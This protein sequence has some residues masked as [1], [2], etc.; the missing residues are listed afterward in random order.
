M[1]LHSPG[2]E[3]AVRRKAKAAVRAVP[4]LK[5]E[6]A[7]NRAHRMRS[8]SLPARAVAS[9]L[10]AFFVWT[11]AGTDG[12]FHATL[13]FISLWAG[14]FISIE[15]GSLAECLYQS[16]DLSALTLLPIEDANIFRWQLQK[17]FRKSL[18]LLLDLVLAFQALALRSSG[19]LLASVAAIVTAVFTWLVVAALACRLVVWRPGLPYQLAG[20]GLFAISFI[21]FAARDILWAPTLELAQRLGPALNM[22]LPTAWP[23][24]LLAVVC[25]KIHWSLLALLA[26]AGFL[27]TGTRS[28]L[29]QLR[30]VYHF[31]EPQA[32]PSLPEESPD[33]SDFSEIPDAGR[34]GGPIAGGIT[35]SEAVARNQLLASAQPSRAPGRLENLLWNWFSNRQRLLAE[36]AFPQGISIGRRWQVIFRDVAVTL[37]A[38]FVCG[39]FNPM[40]ERLVLSFGVFFTGCHVL[41]A[42]VSSGDLFQPHF[43]SGVQTPLF[44]AYPVTPGE[45]AG[46]YFKLSAVQLPCTLLFTMTWGL[47]GAILF[48]FPLLFGLIT[49][50]KAGG[51]VFFSRVIFL[52][53]SL[54]SLSDDSRHLRARSLI[55]LAFIIG[56]GLAFA[57]CGAASLLATSPVVAW[58]C[59]VLAAL[60]AWLFFKTYTWFYNRNWFDLIGTPTK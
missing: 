30:G 58:P 60:A 39:R 17:F 9:G 19:T 33:D 1:K 20:I 27:L 25:G 53:L 41:Y 48:E 24:T 26:P 13:A 12:N 34:N 37:L 23:A 8:V 56:F 28:I 31:Q 7:R 40:A 10:L 2:F 46:F 52:A 54:S 43:T 51:L 15:A 29:E 45:L 11:L 38:A 4:R 16:S 49:G 55:V 5:R 44:L 32:E 35:C 47:A 57:G 14:A 22:L 59:W 21:V 18:W 6:Y 42:N 50:F 3:R 36:I